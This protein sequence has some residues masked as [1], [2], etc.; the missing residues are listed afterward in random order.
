MLTWLVAG[1]AL[2]LSLVPCTAFAQDAEALRRELD[3]LRRQFDAMKAQYQKSIDD[4]TER[5][6]R[7]EAQPA[8]AAPA[9]TPPPVAAQPPAPS[10]PTLVDLA[11]PRP[12]FALQE[13]RGQFLLDV[14]AVGD[15][16]GNLTQDNVD[17]A[18]AGTFAG[19]ENRFFPR[20]V[21]LMVFGQVDPYARGEVRLEAAEEFE[22][23]ARE[24]HVG[25]AEAHLTL[26]TLP[27]G[28]QARLGR[29]RSRFGLLNPLHREALP[30][31]DVPN[32]HARFFGEEGLVEQGVEVSLVPPLP[33]Y[34]EALAGVFAGDNDEAFGRGSLKMPLVTGRLRT[35]LE[36]GDLGALQLGAS[37]A[38]GQTAERRRQL[39]AGYDVKY[40]FTPDGWRHALFTA[41][42]EGIWSKRRIDVFDDLDG[43]GVDDVGERR[44]RHRFGW[45]VYGEVQPWRRWLGGVR[46]DS[47]QPLEAPGREWAIEPYV[48]FAPSEFLRFRLAWK[49]TERDRRGLAG[50]N[51]ATARIVDE[52]LLQAT[53]FLGAHTPHPF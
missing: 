6:G 50:A 17:K 36:L 30:Q 28:T 34:L 51:E 38:T 20:E 24:L 43:D 25:L 22:D 1:L 23:G 35:F 49:H 31:P 5:L 32:V 37:V 53:F 33:F 18:D 15:F 48:A 8:P 40:K 21:E 3:Q 13:R 47:A 52:L 12:P 10:T 16:I 14:G 9:P 45:Y 41:A 46:F 27:L 44:T 29:M 4:L 11:R 19:R 7:L 42:G 26:L 2:A 39:F